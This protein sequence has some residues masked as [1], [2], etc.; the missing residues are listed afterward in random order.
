MFAKT[1]QEIL[2]KRVKE[3]EELLY[4]PHRTTTRLTKVEIGNILEDMK[5]YILHS[6]VVQFDT[7]QVKKKKE[8]LKNIW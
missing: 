2:L 8:E 6:L 5:T 1:T 3:S 4:K 7:L